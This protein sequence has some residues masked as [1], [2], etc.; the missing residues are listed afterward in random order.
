M[1][2]TSTYFGYISPVSIPTDSSIGSRDTKQSVMY[3]A[4]AIAQPRVD[5][6]Y[7]RL[8]GVAMHSGACHGSVTLTSIIIVAVVIDCWPAS[9]LALLLL[10][11][12]LLGLPLSHTQTT[13]RSA[14]SSPMLHNRV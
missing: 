12:L 3:W 7:Q 9:L 10:L 11:L 1:Y 4:S 6:C 2:R 8:R 5:D 13:R 14:A